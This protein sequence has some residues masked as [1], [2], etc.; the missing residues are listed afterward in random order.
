[1]TTTVT[2]PEAIRRPRSALAPR[3][4]RARRRP[5]ILAGITLM[6]GL[7]ALAAWLS[8]DRLIGSGA[9][10]VAVASAAPPWNPAA[11]L[12][13]ERLGVVGLKRQL[14]RAGYSLKVDGRLDPVTK[15]ALADFLR[16]SSAHPLSP[17]LARVLEGTVITTLRNP[18]AWNSRFGLNRKTKFVERPLTGPG[19]QLDANGNIRQP[20]PAMAAPLRAEAVRARNGKIVFV[21]RTNSLVVVNAN[22]SGR[23][24]LARCRP[25][26]ETRSGWTYTRH[27]RGGI[28]G[29]DTRSG[30]ELPCLTRAGRKC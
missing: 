21:D 4:Q 14:V 15:S 1:M 20:V 6:L 24:P 25:R 5:L 30:A 7:V 28:R 18:A 22:G 17:A 13:L 10:T 9:K 2:K 19:G 23:R 16:P 27:R 29:R 12:W 11:S 26:S 8:V 3:S